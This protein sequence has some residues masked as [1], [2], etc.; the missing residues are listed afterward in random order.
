MKRGRGKSE[1]VHEETVRIG[2]QLR[3]VKTGQ[4]SQPGKCED[5]TSE[6]CW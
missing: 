5:D 1:K 2:E 6:Y 3:C 4:W